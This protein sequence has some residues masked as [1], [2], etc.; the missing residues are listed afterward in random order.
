MPSSRATV[1]EVLPPRAELTRSFGKLKNLMS[2]FS[3]RSV[4]SDGDPK[5]YESYVLVCA[6]L[7][8]Y[9]AFFQHHWDLEKC[10][11]LFKAKEGENFNHP[12]TICRPVPIV[13][14]GPKGQTEIHWV[15]WGLKFES[16]AGIG[17]KGTFWKGLPLAQ[18]VFYTLVRTWNAYA[19]G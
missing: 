4:I 7:I 19:S 2:C 11:I 6:V 16:D 18:L 17:Q 5:W 8:E 13:P 15:F 14:W 3:C 1:M 9:Q 12:S 10:S